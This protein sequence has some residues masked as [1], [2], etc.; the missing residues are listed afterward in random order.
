MEKICPNCKRKFIP[1]WTDKHVIYCEECRKYYNG[2]YN[3]KHKKRRNYLLGN[4]EQDATIMSFLRKKRIHED[5]KY[6]S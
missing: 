5:K 3:E 6:Y 1:N 4:A 2:I